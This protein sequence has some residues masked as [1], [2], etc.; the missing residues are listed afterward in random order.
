MT[1]AIII[2]LLSLIC[3]FS[4]KSYMKKLA[5]GCCGTGTDEKQQPDIPSS[6][7]SEYTHQYIV[8]IGGMTCKNCAMRIQ[9]AFTRKGLHTVVDHKSGIATIHADAAVSDFAIRQTIIGLGYSVETI[10]KK[11]SHL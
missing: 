9:N 7:P 1:T 6:S 2:I 11:D 8:Q 5:H 3:V 10:K 4:I